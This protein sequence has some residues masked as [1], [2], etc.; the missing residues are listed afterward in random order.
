MTRHLL[1]VLE[2]PLVSFGREA[3]D[4]RGPV[5]DFPGASLLTGLLANAL[6]YRREQ[7]QAH[8]RL[9]ARLVFAARL[10]RPG[11]RLTDFQTVQLGHDDTGW[12]TRGKPE[13]RAGGRETYNSPHIRYREYDA[14]KRVVVA[15]RLLDGDEPPTLEGLGAALQDPA[16]P[17]FIGRKPCLPTAPLFAGVVDASGLL[18]ALAT[19]PPPG[20]DPVRVEL[21]L[22]EA[23]APNDRT[24]WPSD[25]RDWHSGVH[26]GGRE[27]IVR[28]LA[29]AGP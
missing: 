3:V 1:M 4:A 28:T 8:S 13:G 7:R 2:G 26:A 15:L 24:I 14:D 25:L 20:W 5:S 9:Q 17:L 23:S 12:T 18:D 11:T 21:P 22:D 6:G 10:D 27:R 19:L 29:P 16:R